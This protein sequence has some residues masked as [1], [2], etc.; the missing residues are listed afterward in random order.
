MCGIAGY[1]GPDIK[2]KEKVVRDM[3]EAIF[4]RGPDDDGFFVNNK[5]GLGMRRLSIIDLTRG[6]QPITSKDGSLM[7]FF[8]GE[9]YNYKELKNELLTRGKEFKTDSDTEV[10]LQM[11]ETFGPKMLTRLRGMFAFAIYDEANKALFIAR[12]YFGIKPLYY[13]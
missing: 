1:I 13:W 8:N 5:V 9:I 2:N 12:D 11:Y 6:K 10:I 3:T 4:H 7:I